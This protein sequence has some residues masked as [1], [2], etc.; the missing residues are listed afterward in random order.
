MHALHEPPEDER[1]PMRVASTDVQAPESGDPE[2]L[3]ELQ[4]RGAATS[5]AR[6][7]M[8][9]TAAPRTLN[10]F[11]VA[12]VAT[13]GDG[14]IDRATNAQHTPCRAEDAR[15]AHVLP[16]ALREQGEPSGGAARGAARSASGPHRLSP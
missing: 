12:F 6:I 2:L 1:L 14:P 4:P 3:D 13:S 16:V 11:I 8:A 9:N 15:H 5:M 10:W 7:E